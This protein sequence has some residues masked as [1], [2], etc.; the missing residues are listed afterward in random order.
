MLSSKERQFR[1]FIMGSIRCADYDEVD[2]RI[3]ED[4]VE[5]AMD[6]DGNSESLLYPPAIRG[7]IALENGSEREKVGQGEDERDVEGK[8]SKADTEYASLN[9][10]WRHTY[11]M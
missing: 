5:I 8:S 6:P 2:V 11:R 4:A 9:G 7:G 10:H 3:F 1:E